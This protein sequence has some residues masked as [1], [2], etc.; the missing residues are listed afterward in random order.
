MEG[1]MIYNGI[2]YY[3]LSW[4]HSDEVE[5]LKESKSLL[6]KM[7]QHIAFIIQKHQTD[8]LNEIARLLNWSIEMKIS[9]IT[10]FDPKGKPLLKFF[11]F[12]VAQSNKKGMLK[13]RANQILER[14]DKEQKR[15]HKNNKNNCLDIS[16]VKLILPKPVTAFS[17]MDL[18]ERNVNTHSMKP[19]S[20]VATIRIVSIED[21][22]F[23]II[24]T[25]RKFCEQVRQ[26]KISDVDCL[27]TETFQ[28]NLSINN[29]CKA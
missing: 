11:S 5:Y 3:L 27:D 7:P 12:S 29:A 19:D 26:N 21:G 10:L 25:A 23:D 22:K 14:V 8:Q 15:L 16:K 6:S 2:K 20:F 4:L 9:H 18:E 1:E 28:K 24:Q 17:K 13:T